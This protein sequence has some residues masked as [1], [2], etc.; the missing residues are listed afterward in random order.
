MFSIKK[1]FVP[2]NSLLE[3]Y[4]VI[5]GA[6]TDCYTTMIEKR[7]TFSEFIFAFY[8]TPLFKLERL[9]LKFT[10]SK[11]STDIDARRL[12]DDITDK[13]A[14]WTTENRKENEILMCDFLSRTRS[15]LMLIDNG[16]QTQLYFG[17]AVVPK[18]GEASL[19][20]GFRALLEFHKI[21]SVLLLWSAK[22]MI[23]NKIERGL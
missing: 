18:T 3:R 14:A 17:S 4:S 15:W 9:I 20:F 23:V 16:T 5:N 19:D 6:Y 22:W 10:V 2:A 21:Y 11:P 12:A 1:K 7:I 13:F 8:T